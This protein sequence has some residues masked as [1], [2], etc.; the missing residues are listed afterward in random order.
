MHK[1]DFSRK[2]LIEIVERASTITE[3]C[4]SSFILDE[5][6]ANDAI[7][8]SRLEQ[9]CQITAHGNWEKFEQRLVWDGFDLNTVRRALGSVR[10]SEA[11]QL[12]AWAETLNQC[13]KALVFVSLET[14]EEGTSGKNRVLDPQNQFPFEEV[15][16]PFI[17]VARQ[18]LIA[19]AGSYYELLSEEAHATFERSLLSWLSYLCSSSM[20]LEFSVF[21][22]SR[23]STAVRLLGKSTNEP[24]RE[25]YRDFIQGLLAGG[26]LAFFR[27]YPVL[28]RLVA[29]VTDMWVDATQEFLWRLASDWPEIQKTFQAEMELGQIIAIEHF[30]SDRHHNGRSVAIVTFASGLKLVYKPKDLGLDQAYVKLLAWLNEHGVSLPFKLFKVLNRSTYGW[31]EFV[32]AL[33]C[34]DQ[35][36]A[37]RYYQRSGLLLCLMYVLEAVDLHFENI[38]AC[39][40]HPVLIDLETLMH[41]WVQEVEASE[42]FKR[43]QYLANKQLEHSVLRT[44]LLPRWQLS[45]ENQSFDVSGLGAVGQQETSF[46]VRKWQNINTDNMVIDSEYGKIQQSANVPSLNGV[47]L[48]LND[49]IEEIVDGF[50]QMYRFLMEHR[51]VIMAPDSP[52]KALAHQTVRFVFRPTKI[53]SLILAATLDPKFL[54]DGA[55]RSIQLDILSRVMLLSDTKP[56]LWPLLKVEQQALEQMDIPLFTARSDSDALTVAPDQTIDNCFT[57]PSFNLVV[58]RLNQLNDED[59]EKQISFI[60]GSLYS[61]I[62]DETYHSLQ[63]QNSPL[64]L[65]TV[66][67]LTRQDMVQQAMA[68]A[69]DLQKRAICSADGCAT[70]ISPQYILGAK[71]HQLQPMGHGLYDG[72]CGVA[73]FLAALEKVTREA[74]F[75]DLCLGALRALHQDLQELASDYIAKVFGIS[76]AMGYGSF[77]YALV[78]SSQFLQE[79][80]LL[81]DAKQVASLITPDLIA[82]DNKFDIIS[83]SAGTI[84]GLLAL[85]NSSGDQEALEQALSCG[86]H[87]LNHRVIGDS[88]HKAWKTVDEKL[89]TGFSHGASGIAYALLRLYQVTDEITFLEAAQDAIAYERSLFVPEAGNWLDFLSPQPQKGFICG[90]SWCHGAPGIGLARVAGL[91]V[92]DTPEIRQD[93]EAAINTTK[94]HTLAERDHLCCG[95]L[96]RVEFL[97]TTARRLSQPQLQETAMEQ[98]AQVLARAEQRGKF[99]YGPFLA[100]NPGLFQGAAGIG[101]ELLRL[102][103]PDLLPSVLLWE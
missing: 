81:E 13:L 27:E 84:L 28:A 87:L 12:P 51:Q 73:L 14:L 100:Y 38:I 21:R 3:R 96:G 70:W 48:V 37:R 46:R 61:R 50:R 33:P 68:L 62:A 29:T 1:I 41:P 78:R 35:E 54:R 95:N 18:N 77:I 91:D 30:L 94:Q 15:W 99:G 19:Q 64:S 92:L 7:V 2:D 4:G 16:L 23:Q 34:K 67:P 53:Y 56:L 52:W 76:G 72:S 60:Q 58:S 79:P 97:F 49:Y 90:C 102:A 17:N 65:D 98:A 9:W 32:E 5:V 80:V 75:R 66:A 40:E 44:D 89:L 43:V 8:N 22:A 101:Y 86:H 88:G 63:I 47:N 57:E 93:I 20:E 24:S 31:V 82:A 55:E 25:Q 6:Q 59:L 11:Q 85:H 26:L 10:L 83:G 69:T 103:H 36:E 39:G 42:A 71:R 74:G 45:S